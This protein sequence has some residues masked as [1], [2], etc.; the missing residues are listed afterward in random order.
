MTSLL[1]ELKQI[2][3]EV[4]AGVSE[5]RRR[6]WIEELSLKCGEWM[7]HADAEVRWTAASILYW[8]GIDAEYAGDLL[9]VRKEA[10]RVLHE[11]PLFCNPV[12]EALLSGWDEL[13]WG[14]LH[15]AFGTAEDVPIHLKAMCAEDE[16]LRE[17]GLTRLVDHVR[18]QGGYCQALPYA[19]RFLLRLLAEEYPY[20]DTQKEIIGVL[21]TR[22]VD[23]E[24]I[25]YGK[26]GQVLRE[27]MILYLPYLNHEELA[28]QDQV[29]TLLGKVGKDHPL[30]HRAL[31]DIIERSPWEYQQS[32]ALYAFG[33]L[34]HWSPEHEQL[35]HDWLSFHPSR[36]WQR[37]AAAALIFYHGGKGPA[38]AW[39]NIL[40]Y[41]LHYGHESSP[42][43]QLFIN[44][45]TN[46][47]RESL[48]TD[49][50]EIIYRISDL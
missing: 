30:A 47:T 31:M 6:E 22:F 17:R 32:L 25:V 37:D 41:F 1:H 33:H 4:E 50:E 39:Q 27:G 44:W 42:S 46:Y 3:S 40:D 12:A 34:R 26:A 35:V 24:A 49:L 45:W 5:E 48:P 28:V 19:L 10:L 29:I 2:A 16:R 11:H 7:G 13:D 8:L 23:D 14:A 38:A 43:D 36:D 15:H 21:L 20:P 18:H 9:E